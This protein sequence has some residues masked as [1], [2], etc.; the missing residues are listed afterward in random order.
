[1]L[2]FFVL[3]Q[4]RALSCFDLLSFCRQFFHPSFYLSK[5]HMTI[6]VNHLPALEADFLGE[7]I[8]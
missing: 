6:L 5:S 2:Y 3:I 7:E 8:S 1:M 4:L